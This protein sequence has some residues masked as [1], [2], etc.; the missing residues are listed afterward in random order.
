M[1][2]IACVHTNGPLV[3]MLGVDMYYVVYQEK[4]QT[5]GAVCIHCNYTYVYLM[6][7]C[8]VRIT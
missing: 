6:I 1:Q 7:F 4:K 2:F 3:R 5:M 8:H